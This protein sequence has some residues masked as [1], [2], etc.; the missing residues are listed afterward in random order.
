MFVLSPEREGLLFR[1]RLIW[2]DCIDWI[3]LAQDRDQWKALMN[4]RVP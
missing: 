3:D 4:M 1:F 2:R